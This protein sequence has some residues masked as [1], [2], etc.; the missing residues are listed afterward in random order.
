[1]KRTAIVSL[2]LAALAAASTPAT[3]ENDWEYWSQYEVAWKAGDN[4]QLRLKPEIRFREDFSTHY[5]THLEFGMDWK[6][7]SWLVLAP[8]YRHISQESKGDWKTEKRPEA[9]VTLAWRIG[10]V[11]LSDRNRLE[12]R[13]KDDDE[14]FRYRNRLWAKSPVPGPAGIQAFL[15]EEIFYDFDVD[16][17]NKNRVYAGFGVTLPGGLGADIY[18]IMDSSKKNDEWFRVNILATALKY[19]F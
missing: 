11:A 4:V 13:I 5:Y 18:Y 12:Y 2:C 17:I 10:R 16:E 1:M 3:A 14:A 8:Y 6:I 19:R 15:G 7:R 9:D